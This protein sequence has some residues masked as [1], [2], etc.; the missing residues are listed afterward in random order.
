MRVG[1]ISGTYP[2]L[3]CGIG[4]QTAALARELVLRGSEV[5]V[6]TG[7]GVAPQQRGASGVET[8]SPG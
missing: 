1:M 5:D 7:R 2:N 8:W 4:D 3:R 6:A